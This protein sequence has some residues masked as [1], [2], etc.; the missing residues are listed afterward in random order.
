MSKYIKDSEAAH[1]WVSGMEKGTTRTTELGGFNARQTWRGTRL[2][3]D[4]DDF[5]S[6]ATVVAKRFRRGKVEVYVIDNYSYSSM[7]NKHTQQVWSAVHRW[8]GEKHEETKPCFRVTIGG[9]RGS[10]MCGM[11]ARNVL[12]TM[13]DAAK[14]DMK[15]FLSK[16][17]V[18]RH[19]Y[20]LSAKVK[21][22]EARRF[23]TLL[24][25][26]ITRLIGKHEP[27]DAQLQESRETMAQ[28][29]EKLRVRQELAWQNKR[30]CD[31]KRNAVIKSNMIAKARLFA[32]GEG[33]DDDFGWRD[34][35]IDDSPE[36][37]EAVRI[38]RLL[39]EKDGI[40][41]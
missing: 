19:S 17:H 20:V 34:A 38:R 29:H 7:T 15:T 39:V 26:P 22:D 3:F 9:G 35:W 28:Y 32:T 40:E 33:S 1:L 18:T 25:L 41:M 21:F 30:A 14:E 4:G 11:T 36:L 5:Y 8:T 27:S 2:H 12:T 31:A 23:A 37:M 16:R 10:G 6:Y 24:K 13:V